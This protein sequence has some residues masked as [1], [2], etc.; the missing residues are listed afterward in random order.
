MIMQQALLSSHSFDLF[1]NF[2]L[3]VRL[4]CQ[5]GLSYSTV[6]WT[7][8]TEMVTRSDTGPPDLLNLLK[9]CSLELGFLITW[10]IMN[11]YSMMKNVHPTFME[12]VSS[13]SSFA[14][15]RGEAEKFTALAKSNRGVSGFSVTTQGLIFVSLNIQNIKCNNKLIKSR[16]C[17]VVNA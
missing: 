10:V 8:P 12:R 9:K 15:V 7:K 3:C 2:D 14:K 1:R 11:K 5:S 17:H 6:G 4:P 16:R 13:V